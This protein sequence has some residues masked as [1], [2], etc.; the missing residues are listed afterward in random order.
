MCDQL[1]ASDMADFAEQMRKWDVRA[2]ESERFGSPSL[3]APD[4]WQNPKSMLFYQTLKLVWI[5]REELFSP[6]NHLKALWVVVWF[7]Y[8]TGNSKEFPVT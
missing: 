7:F 5:F 1:P 2:L 3:R 4:S 8:V 6:H